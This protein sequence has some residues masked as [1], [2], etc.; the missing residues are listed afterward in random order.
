[1]RPRLSKDQKAN[2][3]TRRI[4]LG[5]EGMPVHAANEWLRDT[6]DGNEGTEKQYASSIRMW[7]DYWQSEGEDPADVSHERLSRYKE[8]RLLEDEVD[9]GTWNGDAAALKWFAEVCVER[10]ESK[11]V[12]QRQW[13]RLR[14]NSGGGDWW[15]RNIEDEDYQWFSNHGLR[16][17]TVDGGWSEE[18]GHIRTGA[19]DASYANYLLGTGFRR[20]E[21][22]HYTLLDMPRRLP[23]RAFNVG[24]LPAPICKR[25]KAREFEEPLALMRQV[26]R[27]QE[28]EWVALVSGA[29]Q[30]LRRMDHR[31]ELLVVEDVEHRFEPRRCR[32]IIRGRSRPMKLS[33][34]SRE[35][36]RRLVMTAGVCAM[37]GQEEGMGRALRDVPQPDWLVPLAVF[38]GSFTPMLTEATW[39][40]TFR[41]ANRRA[42][43]AAEAEGWPYVPVTPHMLRHTFATNFLSEQMSI[44]AEED[45]EFAQAIKDQ[46]HARV[47]RVFFNPMTR[48]QHL[49][50]HSS[51][52]T[53]QVYVSYVMREG[54]Q[55]LI[56]GDS[57]IESFIEGDT[58]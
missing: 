19:R 27:F 15:P 24:W 6:A 22:T 12:S 16:G 51:P 40:A 37:I 56:P 13:K 35:D 50:G 10:G 41:D 46:D 34:A 25:S 4:L 47:K 3:K 48:L 52:E 39:S 31:E 20:L 32:M 26:K 42:K 17:L 58:A 45:P 29:Q 44:L 9:P 8:V 1:M 36:R 28:T 18:A 23:G 54:Q 11:P 21:G 33:T 5:Y 30:S 38:P 49:L 14:V 43:R 2:L 55:R 57:W 53:T 7:V